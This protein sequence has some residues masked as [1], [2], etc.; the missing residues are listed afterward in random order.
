LKGFQRFRSPSKL[1]GQPARPRYSD[2]A[3]YDGVVNSYL[4]WVRATDRPH[5]P[6]RL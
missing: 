4:A 5:P 1:Y 2:Y 6:S 3:N